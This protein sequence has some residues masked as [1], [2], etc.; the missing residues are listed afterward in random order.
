MQYSAQNA[1]EPHAKPQ[2]S[3]E[4]GSDRV[5]FDIALRSR[6]ASLL[7]ICLPKSRMRRDAGEPVILPVDAGG[8]GAY[9]KRACVGHFQSEPV[10]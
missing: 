7:T 8:Y 3:T 5:G 4:S 2:S 6:V 10:S 1:W 9:R